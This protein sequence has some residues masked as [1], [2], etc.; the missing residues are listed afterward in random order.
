MRA[1]EGLPNNISQYSRIE[2]LDPK[3]SK[4]MDSIKK[5]VT[6]ASNQADLYKKSS[7]WFVKAAII[8][9][10]AIGIF[11]IFFGL[12][13]LL[14]LLTI[15]FSHSFTFV[16]LKKSNLVLGNAQ[17]D[18]LRHNKVK[19]L[20]DVNADNLIEQKE[21]IEKIMLE[22]VTTY[23]GFMFI[24]KPENDQ[25][26]VQLSRTKEHNPYV[27]AIMSINAIFGC[28]HHSD[29][30]HMRDLIVERIRRLSDIIIK[31]LEN[32]SLELSELLNK[33]NINFV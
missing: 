12:A 31:D 3:V 7:A 13:A 4:L 33:H 18:E 24:R 10:I 25:Y 8:S 27:P 16:E 9:G 5:R 22:L 14:G 17:I 6:L 26:Q 32:S 1:V 2:D 28:C 19:I 20:F 15:A 11:N 23:Q 29:S 30:S 21:K